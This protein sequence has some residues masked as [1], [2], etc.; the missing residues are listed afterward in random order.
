[1]SEKK[2]NR[3]AKPGTR[4]SAKPDKYNIFAY[5]DEQFR[6]MFF[7]DG[8][9]G[10]FHPDK[11]L[12]LD[13]LFINGEDCKEIAERKFELVSNW[14]EDAAEDA[15]FHY[16]HSGI[17]VAL[18]HQELQGRSALVAFASEEEI[19]DT[20]YPLEEYAECNK[21]DHY[22]QIPGRTPLGILNY[23]FQD[24]AMLF[25]DSE[26]VSEEGGFSMEDMEDEDM[27]PVGQYFGDNVNDDNPFPNASVL[28]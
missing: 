19:L 24:D 21:G 27:P 9:V 6:E 15:D 20:Y 11:N 13:V 16:S 12:I 18:Y 1:M 4:M 25:N 22:F 17:Y 7:H 14:M 10:E 2:Q 26:M 8:I 3:P 28:G 5:N 23:M